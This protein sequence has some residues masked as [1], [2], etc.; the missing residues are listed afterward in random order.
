MDI[1]KILFWL[2]SFITQPTHANDAL[3]LRW[4]TYNEINLRGF[5]IMRQ[6]GSDPLWQQV[7]TFIPPKGWINGA[8]YRFVDRT[9]RCDQRYNYQLRAVGFVRNGIGMEALYQER[10]KFRCARRQ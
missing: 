2:L 3:V 4:Q 5:V 1:F 8:P 10:G 6:T 9:A 7:G